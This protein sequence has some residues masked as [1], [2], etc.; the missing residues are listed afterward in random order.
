MTPPTHTTT[1]EEEPLSFLRVLEFVLAVI[2]LAILGG[3]WAYS[4]LK[5]SLLAALW[6]GAGG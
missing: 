2:A 3:A 6:S 1:S 5:G 4:W